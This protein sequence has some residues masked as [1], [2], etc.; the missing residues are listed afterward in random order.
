MGSPRI[1]KAT[2]NLT[3]VSSRSEWEALQREVC[4]AHFELVIESLDLSGD[5][6]DE[7][8]D[9]SVGVLRVFVL[10]DLFTARPG[11]QGERNVIDRLSEAPRLARIGVR[12][13]LPRS[14]QGTPP[15]RST[16]SSTSWRDSR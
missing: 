5:V 14:G 8:P 16:R 3:D 2:A 6:L 12:T 11:A 7:L 15:C 4:A 9:D 10:E 13:S 1:D